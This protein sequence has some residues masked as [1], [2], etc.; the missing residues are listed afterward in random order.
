MK[1]EFDHETKYKLFRSV[2]EILHPTISKKN[3]SDYKI[4]VEEDI[5]PVRVFYPKKISH[6]SKVILFVHGNGKIT[7][8]LFKY[9][10]ICKEFTTE[11]NILTIA[12]EYEEEVG[13]YQKVSDTIQYFYERLEKNDIHPEDIILMAD[14]TGANILAKIHETKPEVEVQKEILFYPVLSSHYEDK[15]RYESFVLNAHFNLRLL[16]NL[17]EYFQ[18]ICLPENLNEPFDFHEEKLKEIP[19]TL[20]FVGKVDSLKDEIEEY[21]SKHSDWIQSVEVPFVGHGF[22]R[23]MDEELINEVFDKIKEFIEI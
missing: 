21:T 9:S 18:R 7:D 5:L 11:M 15:N 4:I 12:I 17:E 13:M 6:L 10:D 2:Q 16:E 8:C 23:E 20:I 19:N 1:N 14:S 22:L 3:L